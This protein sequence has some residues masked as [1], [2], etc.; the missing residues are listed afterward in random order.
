MNTMSKLEIAGFAFLIAGLVAVYFILVGAIFAFLWNAILVG[1]LALSLPT[2]NLWVGIGIVA[3]ISLIG[4]FF[5][6]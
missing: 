1:A 5:R 2:I 4:S 6:R 3:L